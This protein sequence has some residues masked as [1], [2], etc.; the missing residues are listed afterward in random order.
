VLDAPNIAYYGQ[1]FGD[2]RFSFQ[3]IDLVLQAL[4]AQV[5]G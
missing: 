1:N 3:Q 5:R 4:K 2:G